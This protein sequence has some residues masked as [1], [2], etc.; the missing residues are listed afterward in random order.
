MTLRPLARLRAHGCVG[1]HARGSMTAS[2]ARHPILRRPRPIQPRFI[3]TRNSTLHATIITAPLRDRILPC[4]HFSDDA[5]FLLCP[6]ALNL[7]CLYIRPRFTPGRTWLLEKLF[8]RS[9]ARRSTTT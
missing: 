7:E 4:V 9:E 2:G 3:V 1:Y 5:R 8:Q 6:I